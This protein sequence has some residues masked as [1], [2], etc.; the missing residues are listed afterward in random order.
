MNEASDESAG[1]WTSMVAAFGALPF[2]IGATMLALRSI[3][4]RFDPGWS[5]IVAAVALAVMCVPI[6]FARRLLRTQ[7]DARPSAGLAILFTLAAMSLP[8]IGFGAIYG[9]PA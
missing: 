6:I 9:D 7:P 3:V 4:W 1:F 5:W 2:F 8:L